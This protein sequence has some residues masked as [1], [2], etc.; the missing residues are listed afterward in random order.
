MDRFFDSP[1]TKSAAPESLSAEY[2]ISFAALLCS[3]VAMRS[4]SEPRAD[5]RLIAK[6]ADSLEVAGLG[7][8]LRIDAPSGESSGTVALA[9]LGDKRPSST[10]SF[11]FSEDG[12]VWFQK[13]PSPAEVDCM[14]MEAAVEFLLDGDWERRS[15]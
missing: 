3:H 8:R 5:W 9:P 6:T 12:Q 11:S 7:R 15:Q 10:I 14:D 2:W 1:R 4:V 13:P